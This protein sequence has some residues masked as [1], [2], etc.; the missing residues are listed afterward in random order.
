[1]HDRKFSV[2]NPTY[3]LPVDDDEV[4]RSDI[5]HRM[6]K[7]IFNGRT[8]VGPVKE[9]LQFGEH[10]H[11][12]DLGTGGGFW[13][14]DIADQF[15][16]VN[17][18]GVDVVPIQ[19]L[20]VPERCSFEIWDFNGLDMPYEDCSFDLIHARSILT[21]IPDYPRFL[22]QISRL[23]RPGGLVILIES[24]LWQF[25]DGKAESDWMY[26]SG[27]RGWFTL[28]ETYRSCL[29]SLGIDV[30]V[31]R[32]FTDLLKKTNMFER[33]VEHEGI[34]PVGFYPR[35]DRLLTVGQLQWMDY[36]LL[37]PALKPL[38]LH[39]GIRE[40]K[41]DRIIKDA[42]NDLYHSEFE[43]SSRLHIAYA[44]RRS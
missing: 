25:A 42:Q 23:L 3:L 9:T 10:R 32:R 20:E 36:D 30:T 29:I 38:F 15:S 24:D 13:A 44:L 4:K 6:I 43:L 12:L 34:I 35:D 40:P 41:V 37:L 18:T 33:I 21:G 31:P 28:W 27:P 17:V 5:H 19:M 7:F 11:V 14:V 16:Y 22:V 26:G 1:M 39:L 8:Y 2:L